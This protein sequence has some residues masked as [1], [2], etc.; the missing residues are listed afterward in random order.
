MRHPSVPLYTPEP[1]IIHEVIGHANFLASQRMADLYQAAGQASRRTETDAG[2]DF[3]S[4]VFWF[5]IEFGVLWEG[6]ELRTYGSG[7][8]SSSGELDRFREAEIRP[9][10]LRAMGTQPYDITVYQPCCS[11]PGRSTTPSTSS[12]PS[13]RPTTTTST[14]AGCQGARDLRASIRRTPRSPAHASSDICRATSSGSKS[15]PA[16]TRRRLVASA[17]PTSA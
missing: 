5:S 3:F 7:I 13:S 14:G 16:C 12:W 6:G 8:L 15:T 4:R 11:P 10:D 9:F 17:S 1:D 2:L